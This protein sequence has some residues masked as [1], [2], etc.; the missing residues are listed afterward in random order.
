MT[1]RGRFSAQP[2]ESQGL[3]ESAQAAL[4]R[5]LRGIYY[6]LPE[7]TLDFHLASQELA[8]KG[9]L[10]EGIS[11]RFF[12]EATNHVSSRFLGEATGGQLIAPVIATKPSVCDMD[13]QTLRLAG[14]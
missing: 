1:P 11:S 7:P 2:N 10:L 9:S 4:Q 12:R 14:V 6:L 5:R 13:L 3:R 8:A